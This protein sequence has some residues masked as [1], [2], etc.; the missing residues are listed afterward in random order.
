MMQTHALYDQITNEVHAR[1]FQKVQAPLYLVHMAISLS[2][3]QMDDAHQAVLQLASELGIGE[4][5]K[6]DSFFFLS[7][8]KFALRFERHNE[9]YSLTLYHFGADSEDIFPQRW[10]PLL[11]DGR[12]PGKMLAG[13]EIIFR[14]RREDPLAWC[15][16][17]FGQRN[18][19]AEEF[20]DRQLAA[21][22]VMSGGATVWTDF[23]ACEESGLVRVLV[24]DRS[25][26]PFQAG[27]LLQ[28]ICE[29]ETYRHVALLALPAAHAAMPLI[30]TLDKQLADITHRM[31]ADNKEQPSEVLQ[32]LMTLA[33]Q[34]EELSA[35]TA[36][37]FSASEAY[38]ALLDTRLTELRQERIEGLQTITQF[39]ERRL[40]PARRTCHAAGRRIEQLSKRIARVSELIRSQ[41][42]LSIEQQNRDLLEALNGRAR[43]Q[44]RLQAKLESFTIIVVTYYAFDLIE[45]TIRNTVPGEELLNDV[46]MGVSFSV[47]LIAGVLWLYVR[48]LLKG[49]DEDD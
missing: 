42:D 22:E 40:E 35:D 12:L 4:Q 18:F 9:F 29:I 38:F 46:L 16:K 44:L 30:T 26:Q 3:E 11:C 7:S 27:R 34:V 2:S 41:V 31:T 17:Y 36:N 19:A 1:P 39:M 45:R 15:R 25:L 32:E 21:S 48:Q 43:R 28:R 5:A 47:P 33:A 23:A 37:R 24:E 10:K 49:Y 6:D 20:G 14:K 8:E 13:V